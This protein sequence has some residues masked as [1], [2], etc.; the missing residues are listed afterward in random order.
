MAGE[1][2]SEATSPGS[3]PQAVTTAEAALPGVVGEAPPIVETS[4]EGVVG[5]V[6]NPPETSFQRA[7]AR[8][9]IIQ[10]LVRAF[11][12]VLLI[13][14]LAYTIYYASHGPKWSD[15]KD[16]LSMVLP[17]VTGLLGSAL[18]FYFGTKEKGI[19]GG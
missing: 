8:T 10:E 19:Q 1:P 5:D 2:S 11:V 14:V 4:L 9:L 12:T 7:T 13:A 3:E 15:Q 6:T 18:G 17:A 16:W